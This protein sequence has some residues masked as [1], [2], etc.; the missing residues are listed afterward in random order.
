MIDI[1]LFDVK[2]SCDGKYMPR[3]SDRFIAS[4]NLWEPGTPPYIK[5]FKVYLGKTEITKE[6]PHEQYQEL[7][8]A[9]MDECVSKWEVI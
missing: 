9:F 7:Y 8:S 3:E 5:D 4:M 1:D 6:L 2:F